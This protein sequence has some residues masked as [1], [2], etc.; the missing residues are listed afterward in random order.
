MAG[1]TY[2]WDFSRGKSV[3]G[4]VL[5]LDPEEHGL[6]IVLEKTDNETGL[7]SYNFVRLI[8]DKHL[9]ISDGRVSDVIP[10]II[11]FSIFMTT[12]FY[13]FKAINSRQ[14]VN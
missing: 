10:V 6:L 2:A 11:G 9:L 5:S 14:R 1:Y 8:E 12:L 13:L 7:S 3:A 4:T